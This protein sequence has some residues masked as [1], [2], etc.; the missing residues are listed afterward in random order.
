MGTSEMGRGVSWLGVGI[1]KGKGG[2]FLCC[3]ADCGTLGGRRGGHG[4]WG[5]GISGS[6]LMEVRGREC[7]GNSGG[8]GCGHCLNLSL[9]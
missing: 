5:D 6:G 7:A 2:T 3:E 1:G 9:S 8:Y 4:W